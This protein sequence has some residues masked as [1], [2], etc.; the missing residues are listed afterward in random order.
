[1][2]SETAG[3]PVADLGAVCFERAEKSVLCSCGLSVPGKAER[4]FCFIP[5]QN[6]REEIRTITIEV[7]AAGHGLPA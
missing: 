3:S 7:C 4:L 6:C 5:T 1:M 2:V